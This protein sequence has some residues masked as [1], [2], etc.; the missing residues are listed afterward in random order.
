M[1]A[2]WCLS[3]T[4]FHSKKEREVGKQETPHT[5]PS[6]W[7]SHIAFHSTVAVSVYNPV[8]I[9]DVTRL[10]NDKTNRHRL[11]PLTSSRR[12]IGFEDEEEEDEEEDDDDDDAVELEAILWFL[13]ALTAG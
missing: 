3:I 11:L 13:G 4:D 1:R 7:F 5:N 2:G 8:W 12:E 6:T 9:S 10:L